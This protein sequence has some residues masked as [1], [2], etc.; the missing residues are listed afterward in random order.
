MQGNAFVIWTDGEHAVR[1]YRN[2]RGE[3]R[4]QFLAVNPKT[5]KPNLQA[6]IAVYA[7][8]NQACNIAES[9][10]LWGSFGDAKAHKFSLVK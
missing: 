1:Q 3:I 4:Y 2:R 9:V 10:R 7:D 5:K 6:V 8:L